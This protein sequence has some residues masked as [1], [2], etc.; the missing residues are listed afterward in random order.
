MATMIATA[1]D[2]SVI[3][4]EAARGFK[5]A[6]LRQQWLAFTLVVP[7]ALYLVTVFVVPLAMMLFKS[8]ENPE[9]PKVLVRTVKSLHGWDGQ[10]LP[11]DAAFRALADDLAEAY[12]N[13]TVA[14]AAKRLNM[15]IS[16]YRSMMMGAA[17]KMPLA[18][19]VDAR[20]AFLEM[21]ERWGDVEYWRA[22]KR[23]GSTFTSHYL[24]ASVDLDTQNGAIVRAPEDQR[25]FLGILGR[26]FWISLIVTLA[27]VVLGYPLA[28]YLATR[29]A[30]TANLLM[31]FVLLPFWTSVLVRIASWIVLLQA[32]GIVNQALM[33]LGITSEPLELVFNRIG[34]YISMTH[35]LLPF[36]VLPVYSV[37]KS[38]PPTYMRAAISLGS[39][40]FAAFWRVY[41][42]QTV[43]GVSAGA[44]LVFI[45]SIGY[46]ITPA[47]LGSPKEQM[48]SYFVAF[49]TN[50]TINWGM[51]AALGT[52]LLVTTLALY[53]VYQAITGGAKVK[54]G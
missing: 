49:Y 35:I 7:L 33:G 44:I 36:M 2:A 17:R 15:E 16:G 23:N 27:C 19:E 11:G 14:N 45:M 54:L 43:A 32:G 47:L 40:P 51:A 26:T 29:P 12:E 37:M 31:V 21:D 20:A 25:I 34:V 3:G 18:A 8:V 9:V 4:P 48:L 22:I 6:R 5:R 10:Q 52:V 30:R 24:L 53:G 28:Y 39:H 38:I 13:Q 46:Y 41:A 42:P 1:D 50:V